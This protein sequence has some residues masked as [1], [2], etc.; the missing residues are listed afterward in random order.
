MGDVNLPGYV[1]ADGG[2]HLVGGGP[3]SV[4]AYEY[5]SPSFSFDCTIQ[6]QWIILCAQ[7]LFIRLR[8]R[9]NG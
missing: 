5:R 9:R 3:L 8:S 6:S 1:E 4:S 7:D 2:G